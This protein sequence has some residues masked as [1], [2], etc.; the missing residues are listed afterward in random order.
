[1]IEIIFVRTNVEK[2]IK[3][4]WY[5]NDVDR[6]EKEL[7]NT[8]W[9]SPLADKICRLSF[10]ME[11]LSKEIIETYSIFSILLW[12]SFL[13]C[14][15]ILHFL[16][17]NIWALLLCSNGVEKCLFVLLFWYIFIMSLNS[18]QG[19]NRNKLIFPH[20]LLINPNKNLRH[21]HSC[22]MFK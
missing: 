4:N 7:N 1:M 9:M 3:Q 2:Q 6:L 14:I 5:I 16:N 10:R 18:L 15:C 17:W 13:P 19:T 22:E 8:P 12:Q 11:S 21:T 20:C